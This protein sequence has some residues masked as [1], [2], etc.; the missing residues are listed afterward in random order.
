MS[1]MCCEDNFRKMKTTFQDMENCLVTPAELAA[2][3]HT[4]QN[5]RIKFDQKYID[6]V[7]ERRR[8]GQGIASITQGGA[9]GSADVM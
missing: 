5:Y 9:A 8:T 6:H 7:R 4:K 2:F 3:L 1:T